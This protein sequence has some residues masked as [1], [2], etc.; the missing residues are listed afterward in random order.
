MS[1]GPVE[2]KQLFPQADYQ[3]KLIGSEVYPP[4]LRFYI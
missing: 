2:R 3:L 4:I 1:Y